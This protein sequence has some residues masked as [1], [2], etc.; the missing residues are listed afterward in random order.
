MTCIL[1]YEKPK[2]EHLTLSNDVNCNTPLIKRVMSGLQPNTPQSLAPS[3]P[4]L[5]KA[6]CCQ[7]VSNPQ[8]DL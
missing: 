8:P 7:W 5:R 1:T 4:P 2:F 3:V 6:G